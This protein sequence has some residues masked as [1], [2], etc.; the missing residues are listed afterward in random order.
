MWLGGDS[1]DQGYWSDAVTQHELGHWVMEAYGTSPNEGGQHFLGKPTF[2]GQA[3]SEGWATW[4]SSDVR[5]DPIYLDKQ[6]GGMFWLDLSLHEYGTGPFVRPSPTSPDGLLQKLDENEVSA[7]LW[8]ISR[9]ST[10]ASDAVFNALASPRMKETP[11]GRGYTRHTWD[12]D[13][14]NQFI[15]VVDTG[16]SRPCFAD[17]LDALN[18][19]GFSRAALDEATQ[20][21]THYPYDSNLPICP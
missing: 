13:A 3:W 18:C 7:M 1:T 9:S 20:P 15:N 6:G 4:F 14:D 21:A 12:F 11:F 10:S 5:D 17:V 16:E 2:P 19:A 8:T